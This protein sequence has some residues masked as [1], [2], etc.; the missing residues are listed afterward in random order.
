MN[1]FLTTIQTAWNDGGQG[2]G[3]VGQQEN[4]NNPSGYQQEDY[5]RVP[6]ETWDADEDGFPVGM[7]LLF[8]IL[9]TGFLYYRKNR[10]ASTAHRGGYQRV[11]QPMY[12][13]KRS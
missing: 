13:N 9:L 6:A 7:M 8:L 4:W 1:Y 5:N 2:Y 11:E 3:Q 10:Q 12:M